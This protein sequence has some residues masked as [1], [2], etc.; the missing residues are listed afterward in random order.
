M[1]NRI[2]FAGSY[3]IYFW[4]SY[5]PDINKREFLI[6]FTLVFFTVLFGLYSTPILDGLHYYTYSLLFNYAG[7]Q[8]S[9]LLQK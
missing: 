3:F 9:L 2:A 8:Y 4:E 5:I 7:P 6:T 1:F